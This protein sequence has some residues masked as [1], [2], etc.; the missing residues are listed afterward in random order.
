M[1]RNRINTRSK[2]FLKAFNDWSSDEAGNVIVCY[3]IVAP[4]KYISLNYRTQ[5]SQWAILF[6]PEALI[7]YFANQYYKYMD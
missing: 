2:K 4:D 6:S 3:E 5:C 7:E 1:K